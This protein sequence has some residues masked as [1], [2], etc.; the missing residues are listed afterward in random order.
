MQQQEIS[1]QEA[2]AEYELLVNSDKF[3]DWEKAQRIAENVARRW[4]QKA[5]TAER[6]CNDSISNA[7]TERVEQEKKDWLDNC[8]RTHPDHYELLKDYHHAK[9][10]LDTDPWRYFHPHNDTTGAEPVLCGDVQM[11]NEEVDH[12]CSLMFDTQEA[13]D[14]HILLCHTY[15]EDDRESYDIIKDILDKYPQVEVG[16][17]K[18]DGKMHLGKTHGSKWT[19]KGHLVAGRLFWLTGRSYGHSE[20]SDGNKWYLEHATANFCKRCFPDAEFTTNRTWEGVA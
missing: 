3:S 18:S 17:V 5:G 12:I 8:Q 19:R 20:D 10:P 16:M 13:L 9:N 7:N 14:E 11:R 6:K 1:D 2:L 4:Q 15:R